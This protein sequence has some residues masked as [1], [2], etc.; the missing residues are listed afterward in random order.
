MHHNKPII[1]YFPAVGV[2]FCALLTACS[3]MQTAGSVSDDR[4]AI[5]EQR[6][7]ALENNRQKAV[8]DLRAETTAILDRVQKEIENFRKAQQFF[9]AELDALKRDAALIT[10]ENEKSG[11]QIRKNTLQIARIVKRLG[12]QVLALE[13][14]K[15]FFASSIDTSDVVSEE[16]K[17]AFNKA[18]RQYR[19]KNF[20][21]SIDAFEKFRQQYPDSALAQD[22]LFFIAY[23]HFL[24]GRYEAANLRFFEMIEQYPGSKRINDA[25]W[26]LG[27]SL[28]RTGDINGAKD[29]Y[30][31]LAEL[32]EQDPLHIKAIFRLE[33]LEAKAPL[34]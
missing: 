26:W 19:I 1:R 6:V 21:V 22:S 17:T 34:E 7:I 32:D 4:I 9:L 13:E 16:E 15:R 10:N 2:L 30:R 11:N 20:K 29:L 33:E 18:F 24:S 25:K 3:G 14:L 12:D 28:E 31:Q 8:A 5:L 27:I 23:S